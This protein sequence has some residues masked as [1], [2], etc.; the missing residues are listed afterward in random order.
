MSDPDEIA[1][2]IPDYRL[3]CNR[4][5]LSNDCTD[6]GPATTFTWSDLRC[7]GH[8]DRCGDRHGRSIDADVLIWCTGFKAREFLSPSAS[9]AATEWTCTPNGSTAPRRTSAISAINFPNMFM[10]FGPNTNSITNTI[11][12]PLERQAVYIRQALDYKEAHHA[13]W[14]DSAR[15]QRP[16]PRLASEEA[17]RNGLHRQLPG[18]YTTPKKG[19]GDVAGLAPG[20]MPRTARFIPSGTRSPRALHVDWPQ[21]PPKPPRQMLRRTDFGPVAWSFRSARSICELFDATTKKYADQPALHSTDG[22]LT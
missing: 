11:D 16:I 14:V 5:L 3:L 15:K 6:A 19:H 4:L 20:P 22:E 1:A 8:A 9:S 21:Y 12:V 10:L 2:A 7:R 17:R 18:W 13:A